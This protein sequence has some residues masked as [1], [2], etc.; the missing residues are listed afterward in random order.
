MQFHFRLRPVDD[1][2]AWESQGCPMLHWFGLTDGWFWI[3]VE[4]AELFRY[5]RQVGEHWQHLY[6]ELK[7][8]PL[9]YEDYQVARYWEDLLYLLPDVLTPLPDDLA[10]RVAKGQEWADWQE[11]AH[12]WQEESDDKTAS[13]TCYTAVHWWGR[14][15]WHAGHLV[16]PPGIHLWRVDDSV[17]I[18]WD[19]RAVTVDGIPVWEA[20]SGEATFPVSEFIAAVRSFDAAF[21]AAMAERVANIRRRWTRRDVFI[22]IPDLERDHLSRST[23]MAN[24]LS[25]SVE[26][27][28]WD[29]VRSAITTI[30]Q[31][32]T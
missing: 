28:A 16:R 7:P 20:Q 13:D 22:D 29:D 18:R 21:I 27:P 23:L 9:P 26:P 2:P 25:C 30:E 10:A 12:R 14:R 24:I 11:R 5:T 15:I 17:S 31:A 3:E 8:S 32:M 4:G 19:N 6:P 1:I